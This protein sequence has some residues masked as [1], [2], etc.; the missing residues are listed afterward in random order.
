MAIRAY[1]HRDGL[2]GICLRSG[3]YE[4]QRTNDDFDFG[5]WPVLHAWCNC[6]RI[7]KTKSGA[8]GIWLPRDFPL[9]YGLGIYVPL[10]RGSTYC[11]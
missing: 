2:G 5:W 8:G 3:L 6:L 7:Q 4:C 9:V 1:L 10:D 11:A